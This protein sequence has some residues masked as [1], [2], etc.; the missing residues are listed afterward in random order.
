MQHTILF[1]KKHNTNWLSVKLAYV[2]LISLAVVGVAAIVGYHFNHWEGRKFLEIPRE[3]DFLVVVKCPIISWIDI[4]Y[5]M[6]RQTKNNNGSRF[7]YGI[8]ICCLI[9]FTRYDMV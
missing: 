6:E 7:I 8:T 2:Q 9:I 4:S 3:L 5:T 1:L